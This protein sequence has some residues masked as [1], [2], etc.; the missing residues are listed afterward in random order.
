MLKVLGV[1][2]TQ[3]VESVC[4]IFHV[5]G[6]KTNKIIHCPGK[7]KQEY[8]CVWYQDKQDYSSPRYM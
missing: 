7:C 1:G 5:F 8:H 2:D 3:L 6:V 4:K